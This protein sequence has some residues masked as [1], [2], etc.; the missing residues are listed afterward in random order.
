VLKEF[1]LFMMPAAYILSNK[2][3]FPIEA[4]TNGANIIRTF[5]ET[6]MKK[7]GGKLF[8]SALKK[9]NQLTD[10]VDVLYQQHQAGRK[11][12]DENNTA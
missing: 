5:V 10:L 6:T 11:V 4:I 9:A 2:E 7:A 3:Y 8:V 12:T 1:Y